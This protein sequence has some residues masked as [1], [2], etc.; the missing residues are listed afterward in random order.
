MAPR[1][2]IC[3]QG[4]RLSRT[5]C[6]PGRESLNVPLLKEGAEWSLQLHSLA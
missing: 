3:Y 5:V 6:G 4:A 1:S 2:P